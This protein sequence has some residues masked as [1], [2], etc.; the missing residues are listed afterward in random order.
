MQ[1]T[2]KFWGFSTGSVYQEFGHYAA[3]AACRQPHFF[4]F[5]NKKKDNFFSKYYIK[6][7]QERRNICITNVLR[8]S[9]HGGQFFL[10]ATERKREKNV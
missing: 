6:P 5:F 4:P 8:M 7:I 1:F 2:E 9:C 3:D 10:R